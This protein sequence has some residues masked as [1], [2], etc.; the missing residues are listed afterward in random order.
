MLQRP[1]GREPSPNRN[2]PTQTAAAASSTAPAGVRAQGQRPLSTQELNAALPQTRA[3]TSRRGVSGREAHTRNQTL[4]LSRLAM[5][6]HVMKALIEQQEA[7]DDADKKARESTEAERFERPLETLFVA[8]KALDPRTRRQ[9][10]AD[11][12]LAKNLDLLMDIKLS[13]AEDG[14]DRTLSMTQ[15]GAGRFDI[16][17]LVSLSET[18]LATASKYIALIGWHDRYAALLPQH[19][20]E[21]L[22]LNSEMAEV[23]LRFSMLALETAFWGAE[24]GLA[25]QA[26]GPGAQAFQQHCQQMKDGSLSVDQT[27]HHL[28]EELAK[29][30]VDDTQVD[31]GKL[32]REVQSDFCDR[33]LDMA[34][35]LCDPANESNSSAA[36]GLDPSL[37][38]VMLSSCLAVVDSAQVAMGKAEIFESPT[39]GRQRQAPGQRSAPAAAAVTLQRNDRGVLVPVLAEPPQASKS[40]ASTPAQPQTADAAAAQVPPSAPDSGEAASAV[41]DDE[42]PRLVA[43]EAAF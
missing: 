5:S 21:K 17:H 25:P 38:S 9:A 31:M 34:A 13:F 39:T 18:A 33:V 20:G 28:P 19:G 11:K 8:A 40:S 41:S 14:L 24:S 2:R 22:K 15:V 4:A 26:Q 36:L 3:S 1:S 27:V 29:L 6:L 16:D 43:G 23:A 35:C 30:G 37:Q 42:N 7:D 12:S 10:V 32:R